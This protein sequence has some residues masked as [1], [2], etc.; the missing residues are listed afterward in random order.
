MAINSTCWQKE[1][2]PK[3]PQCPFR[4]EVC[5]RV[6]GM[7]RPKHT[8]AVRGRTC[9]PC[10]AARRGPRRTRGSHGALGRPQPDKLE[11]FMELSKPDIGFTGPFARRLVTT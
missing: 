3:L 11:R 7:A 1:Q 9:G 8:Q 4:E 6:C 5:P 10:E 2:P